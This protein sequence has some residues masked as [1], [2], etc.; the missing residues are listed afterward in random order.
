M[1]LRFLNKENAGLFGNSL[2][3]V[4]LPGLQVIFR[5]G[6]QGT[7]LCLKFRMAMIMLRSLYLD[8]FFFKGGVGGGG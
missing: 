2:A 6:D 7:S 5:R 3:A 8:A 4:C 1:C